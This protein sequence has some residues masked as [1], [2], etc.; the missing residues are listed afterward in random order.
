MITRPLWKGLLER[1]WKSVPVVWLT[2]VRRAGKT[3]L[4]RSLPE[5]TYLNCDLPSVAARVADP[6]SFY[7]SLTTPFVLF[8][9]IH[10]LPDPSRLLKIG[11]DTRPELRILATGSSTL[12]A[13]RKFRDSLTGRKR[14]VQLVP[15]LAEELPAFGVTRLEDR[16]FLGGLPELLLAGRADPEYR[17]EWLDS[18][19]ARDVQELFRVEKRGAF[20]LLAEALLRQSGGLLDISKLAKLV[21]LSRPT[22]MTYLEALTVTHV[23]HVLRPF[24]GGKKRELLAQPKVYGF[25]TGF[26]AHARG[27]TD[28][29]PEDLGKLW[30]H[31]V[32]DTL[33]ALPG[34]QK[35]H[36]WRDR[37]QREIDFVLPRGRGACDA[38]ECKWNPATLDGRNLAAFRSLHPKGMNYVVAPYVR[39]PY[40]TRCGAL[41]VTVT[42]AANLRELLPVAEDSVAESSPE[43]S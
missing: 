2:G 41:E 37:S 25:D 16:L 23:V 42:G 1:A 35:I 26:V 12:S 3:T 9:E 20:L 8:D 18:Y 39:E 15:V 30:E 21:G 34:V 11:A 14:S 17:S 29:R 40:R 36:F 33:L 4:V 43:H 27:W 13:T 5:A 28:L 10:Q 38:L 22:V 24:H 19:Y 32:L 7:A 6:E 31:L